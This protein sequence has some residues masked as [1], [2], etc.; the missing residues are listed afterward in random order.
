[1]L[2]NVTNDKVLKES[3]ERGRMHGSHRRSIHPWGMLRERGVVS[4]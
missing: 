1:M 3:A 4:T 2:V